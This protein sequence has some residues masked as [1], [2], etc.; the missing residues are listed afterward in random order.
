MRRTNRPIRVEIC[1]LLTAMAIAPALLIA[2][3]Q[4]GGR[5][6]PA[7][8]PAPA[9]AAAP[10]I[11]IVTKLDNSTVRGTIVSSDFNQIVV[12]PAL[13]PNERTPGEPVTLRWGEI[14]RVSNGLTR[15]KV[16]DDY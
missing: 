9:R 10:V 15:Q 7:P 6:G 3:Q 1:V 2:Q 5:R 16:L 4:R 14:L 12:Q 8:A 13:R 11:V